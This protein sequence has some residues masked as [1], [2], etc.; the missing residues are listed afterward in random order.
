MET[1][2]ERQAITRPRA[3][4]CDWCNGEG[5][6]WNR[7]DAC[8]KCNGFGDVIIEGEIVEDLKKAGLVNVGLV[9]VCAFFVTLG[10]AY[11]YL[12]RVGAL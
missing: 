6:Q 3:V 1:K 5:V 12:W 2:T 10:L 11:L 7:L 9:M 8:P 4:V